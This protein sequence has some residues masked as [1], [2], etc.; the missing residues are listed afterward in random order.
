VT[1]SK[2]EVRKR[3]TSRVSEEGG[4]EGGWARGGGIHD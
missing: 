2:R 1:L 3:E 4:E